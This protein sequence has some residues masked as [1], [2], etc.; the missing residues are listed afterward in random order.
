MIYPKRT[1]VA[2]VENGTVTAVGTPSSI[3]PKTAFPTEF[4]EE[5]AEA[6]WGLYLIKRKAVGDGEA[7]VSID[8]Y[9]EANSVYENVIVAQTAAEARDAALAE[10]SRLFAQHRDK[11]VTVNGAKIETNHNAQQELEALV[12]KLTR[13]GGTQLIR[14]RS[15]AVIKADLATAT[16]LRDAVASHVAAVWANDATLGQAIQE[17]SETVGDDA[18]KIAAINAIDIN[19]GWPE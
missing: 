4:T 10:L 14:T 1:R 6:D 2:Q 18:T 17:A 9:F 8:P 13:D 11:G 15:G 3:Y 5:A 12:G 7:S 19:A 16:A